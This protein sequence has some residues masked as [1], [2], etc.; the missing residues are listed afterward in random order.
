MTQGH[1]HHCKNR[2]SSGHAVASLMSAARGKQATSK[3]DEAD[4]P[5]L[6]SQPVSNDARHV[7]YR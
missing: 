1:E 2:L 5:A 4:S 6:L 7:E 3:V